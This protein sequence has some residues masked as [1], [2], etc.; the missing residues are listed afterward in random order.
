MGDQG[1]NIPTFLLLLSQCLLGSVISWSPKRIRRSRTWAQP[2]GTQGRAEK[3]REWIWEWNSICPYRILLVLWFHNYT[4]SYI[5]CFMSR[6]SHAVHN[7]VEIIV[8][9]TIEIPVVVSYWFWGAWSYHFALGVQNF[10]CKYTGW[11]KYNNN[12]N[13]KTRLNS[14]P[15]CQRIL[16]R[17]S[18]QLT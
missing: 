10:V 16:F 3:D 7:T 14:K 2:P 9:I 1:W 18:K 15:H 8:A 5:S 17:A 11:N 13:I 12:N 6:L 4:D